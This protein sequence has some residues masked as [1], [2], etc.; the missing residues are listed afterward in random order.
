MIFLHYSIGLQI[1]L[2]PR[3]N[4]FFRDEYAVLSIIDII[5]PG[6]IYGVNVGVGAGVGSVSI[7][8]FKST[9]S[10]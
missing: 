9:T 3:N 6:N 7:G 1:Y 10:A 5:A 4:C 2:Y 8:T